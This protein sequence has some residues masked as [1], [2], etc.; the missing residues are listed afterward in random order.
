MLSP[1]QIDEHVAEIRDRVTV[2]PRGTVAPA[3]VA[4]VAERFG[5]LRSQYR[6][7]PTTMSSQLAALAE[8]RRQFDTLLDACLEQVVDRYHQFSE[9]IRRAEHERDFL[10]QY[11]IHKF[12]GGERVLRGRAAEVVVQAVTGRSVPAAGTDSRARLEALLQQTRQWLA[13]SQLS[14]SKLQH[15]LEDA[16][17]GERSRGEIDKLCPKTVTHRVISRLRGT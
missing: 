11:L 16:H 5:V 4:A 6:A 12:A 3:D 2:L 1:Q 8:L 15:A 17:F 9:T 13:V 7:A 14:R 10:R